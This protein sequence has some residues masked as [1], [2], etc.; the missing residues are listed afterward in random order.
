M[1]YTTHIQ[2]LQ[3]Q[4]AFAHSASHCRRAG[5]VE[6]ANYLI[7]AARYW[8]ACLN[9]DLGQALL[10]SAAAVIVGDQDLQE[11]EK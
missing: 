10:M 3:D 9:Y 8:L 6:F 2:Y 11:P 5:K 1:T 7:A 4:K